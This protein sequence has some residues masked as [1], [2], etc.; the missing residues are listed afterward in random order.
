MGSARWIALLVFAWISVL[1]T[2]RVQCM[3]GSHTTI[4]AM[5]TENFEVVVRI[6]GVAGEVV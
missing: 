2:T 1:E 6:C 3:G 4:Y 5:N